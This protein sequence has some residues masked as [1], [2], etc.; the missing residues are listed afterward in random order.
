MRCHPFI[1]LAFVLGMVLLLAGM[2]LGVVGC[3]A[4]DV[5]V[6]PECTRVCP[7]C[8]HRQ[9]GRYERFDRCPECLHMLPLPAHG[10][11]RDSP[12]PGMLAPLWR[13]RPQAGN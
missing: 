8:L 7:T 4:L 13:S 2:L 6:R 10:D 12:P 1:Y 9:E 11:E 5:P 3:A